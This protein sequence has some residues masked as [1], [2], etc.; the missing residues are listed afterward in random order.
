[1][2]G[3][4]VH[5]AA[6]FAPTGSALHVDGCLAATAAQASLAS[7]GG[8]M[9]GSRNA[10]MG[11]YFR[12]A[13]GEVVVFPRALNASEL[14]ALADYFAARW[15][16]LPPKNHC[17]AGAP[18]PGLAISQAYAASR[19]QNAVQ[20]RA[21]LPPSSASP[22]PAVIKRVRARARALVDAAPAS[23]GG[24]PRARARVRARVDAAPAS[25]GGA[26][27]TDRAFAAL[28]LARRFNGMAF[29]SNKPS[30]TSGPDIRHWGPDKRVLAPLVFVSLALSL[31]R[32]HLRSRHSFSCRS[33]SH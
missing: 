22:P 2:R 21:V 10:E 20:S 3:R 6:V 32:G 33:R 12:G 8:V 30:T 13:V 15:P 14:G 31:T 28:Q 4:L 9:V 11:R 26:P 5:A 27:L 29:T 24:A 17:H 19:F 7:A 1:V 16:A 25:G 18:S 23:G